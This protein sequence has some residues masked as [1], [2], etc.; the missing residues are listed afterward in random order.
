M[1]TG[2][3]VYDRALEMDLASRDRRSCI[4]R[5]RSIDAFGRAASAT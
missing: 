1:D 2:L 5:L 4:E 3:G